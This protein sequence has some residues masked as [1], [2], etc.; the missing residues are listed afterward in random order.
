M[1]KVVAVQSPGTKLTALLEER[2]YQV[3]DLSASARSHP[4]VDAILHSGYHP[5]SV[6]AASPSAEV[7]DIS[8]GGLS[9]ASDE[10]SGPI[11]LNITGLRP[12]QAV[13]ALDSRLRHRHWHH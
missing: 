3:V 12:E 7:A 1:A 8:W 5:D 4:R 9:P 10:L 11:S 6:L 13:D 2:G